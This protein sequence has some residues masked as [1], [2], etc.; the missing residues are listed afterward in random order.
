MLLQK[1][2][3][4]RVEQDPVG[5]QRV[6]HPDI[7]G[8]LCSEFRHPPEKAEPGQRRLPALEGQQQAVASREPVP[9]GY[10]LIGR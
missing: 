6:F 7:R 5:L 4:L 10:T 3:P 9:E 1:G 2:A 8:P